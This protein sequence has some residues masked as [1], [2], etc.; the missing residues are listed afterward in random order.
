MAPTIIALELSNKI[1]K[2]TF[3]FSRERKY[4]MF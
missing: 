1:S 4:I 3:Q 2:K